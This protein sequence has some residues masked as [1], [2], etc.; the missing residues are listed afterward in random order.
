MKK[1]ILALTCFSTIAYG[2]TKT[3][4]QDGNFFALGTW[5]CFCLPGNGDT[6]QINHTVTMN[7]GI[8]YSA[9]QIT[10]G[11]PGTLTD[12]GIDKDV[13]INGGS[14]FNHGLVDLDGFWVDSGYVENSGIMLLDSLWT[15]DYF[16]NS[17][18]ITVF[19]FLHDQG[20]S[21][22]ND[23]VINVTNNFNNQGNFINWQTLTVVNDAA[24]CNIQS[25]TATLWNYGD[26]CVEGDFSNCGGDTLKG[27]G[28]VYL[29]GSSNNLGHVGGT[30]LINTP[31]SGFTLNTGTVAGTVTFGNAICGLGVADNELD[32]MVYPNPAQDVLFL[33]EPNLNYVIIDMVGRTVLNGKSSST[34]IEIGELS[35]GQYTIQ[36]ENEAGQTSKQNFI[37]L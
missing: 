8:P 20:V 13:Y 17:G 1:I 9:G 19:D 31:S 30:L 35:A 6:L 26:F 25:L 29:A 33:A 22:E 7:A 28:T 18:T 3:T 15:Q 5:D 4:V 24:N 16:L 10:V 23:G 11:V 21:F 36:L 34:K 27:S 12:N 32:W 14:F 2:Q 37:K